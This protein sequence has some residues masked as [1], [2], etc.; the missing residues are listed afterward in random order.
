MTIKVYSW[1]RV[2]G[3]VVEQMR[4]IKIES[5]HIGKNTYVHVEIAKI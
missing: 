4:F 2:E 3:K 5:E 1:Y